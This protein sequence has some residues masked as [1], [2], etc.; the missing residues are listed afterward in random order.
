MIEHKF[1]TSSSG[2]KLIIIA[3]T[4]HEA[5]TKVDMYFNIVLGLN[6]SGISIHW[7]YSYNTGMIYD[8]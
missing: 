7:N 3:N 1:Y 6:N 5:M 4:P 2:E 8:D